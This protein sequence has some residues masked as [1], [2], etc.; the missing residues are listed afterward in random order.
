MSA[1]VLDHDERAEFERLREEAEA[2]IIHVTANGIRRFLV[3]HR[4]SVGVF[5]IKAFDS[6][7]SAATAKV[8]ADLRPPRRGAPRDASAIFAGPS[9]AAVVA[10]HPEWF[11]A[12]AG[13]TAALLRMSFPSPV[14]TTS[15][16]GA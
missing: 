5:S 2:G 13:L 3:T 6:D 11:G 8:R 7:R 10:H 4:A 16:E 14:E 12:D 9:L 15:K 1:D